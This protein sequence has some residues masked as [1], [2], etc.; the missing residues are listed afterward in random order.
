MLK[1]T[2]VS[3]SSN[4]F[5]A[6]VTFSHNIEF[7]RKY[8]TAL[9]T[10]HTDEKSSDEEDDQQP[11]A[12]SGAGIHQAAFAS[13]YNWAEWK[14]QHETQLRSNEGQKSQREESFADHTHKEKVEDEDCLAEEE[15][16]T[17][18]SS[19]TKGESMCFTPMNV[20][21]LTVYPVDLLTAE[22]VTYFINPSTVVARM[23]SQ[24]SQ[25]EEVLSGVEEG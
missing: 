21:S 14:N 25:V 2:M 11:F 10:H 16:D 19:Q 12:T 9:S 18:Q 15:Q 13:G 5:V 20:I 4:T 24:M 1:G 22:H 3:K 6:V 7:P 17:Y 23:A 8:L